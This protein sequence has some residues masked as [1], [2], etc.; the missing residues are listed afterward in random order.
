MDIKNYLLDPNLIQKTS[1]DNLEKALDGNLDITDPTNP[2]MFL[3][4]NSANVA[5]S[6]LQGYMALLRRV[7]PNLAKEPEDLFPHFNSSALANIYS[8]PSNAIFNLIINIENFIN[9]STQGKGY[10]LA[11]IPKYS[12]IKVNNEYTFT[13]LNNVVIKYYP[14]SKKIIC[15][16]EGNSEIE[17]SEKENEYLESSIFKDNNGKDWMILRIP[18]KQLTRFKISDNFIS[19]MAYKKTFK[20]EDYFNYI[21][22]K[23]LNP[24]TN[25]EIKLNITHD[26]YNINPNIP[27]MIVK[28]LQQEVTLELPVIYNLKGVVSDRFDIELFTTKGALEVPIT[29]YDTDRFVL[30][31]VNEEDLPDVFKISDINHFVTAYTDITGGKNEI[32]F[33]E[34]KNRI[35]D[36]TTGDNK[37]PLTLEEIKEKASRYGYRF[38][39]VLDTI[40]KREFLINKPIININPNIVIDTN[41]YQDFIRF[42]KPEVADTK[43]K[44]VNEDKSVIIEPYQMFEFKDGRLTILKE[45][46]MEYIRNLPKSNIDEY[47]N[48]KIFFNFF[49]YI[50]DNDEKLEYRIYD[51]S[52]PKIV[53]TATEYNNDDLNTIVVIKSRSVIRYDNKYIVKYVIDGN[54]NIL[55]LDVE[56]LYGE[57]S[58]TLDN[59]EEIKFNT[60]AYLDNTDLI[61]EFT[62]PYDPYITK[63]DLMQIFSN[64]GEINTA[65]IGNSNKA[66][67]RLYTKDPQAAPGHNFRVDDI[68]DTNVVAVIYEDE[69]TLDFLTRIDTLFS[70]YYIDYTERKF[71]TYDKDV[72]LTYSEDV[73]ELDDDGLPKLYPIYDE[74]GNIVDY[75]VKVLHKKGDVVKNENGDPIVK[76]KKGDIILDK[77]GNPIIDNEV[78]VI[79]NINIHLMEDIYLRTSNLDYVA[80]ILDYHKRLR[81]ILRKEILEFNKQLLE[82]TKFKYISDFNLGKVI[83]NY[84]YSYLIFDNFLKPTITLYVDKDSINFSLT[85]EQRLQIV[86]IIEKYLV[87]NFKINDLE[88]EIEEFLGNEVKSIKIDLLPNNDIRYI[89]YSEKSTKFIIGKRLKFNDNGDTYVD[90]DVNIVTIKI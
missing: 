57:L 51:V 84:N 49:K 2:F 54:T 5:A 63:N 22:V 32:D 39:Y 9:N 1:L 59:N 27:T 80:Y 67:F 64:Y 82:N 66:K 42:T 60:K 53:S 88:K 26:D 72:Y 70:N 31:I 8:S 68:S 25:K 40:F 75:E 52:E 45:K 37:I 79:H 34:L 23:T 46:E 55:E 47:N 62:I 7:Y 36:Y 61:F 58:V 18:M 21:V 89:D 65:Y 4:E 17:I 77:N 83:L 48:R 90:A 35:I 29:K 73:Y 20:I 50:L 6:T 11:I 12:Y 30:T 87:D 33:M 38:R 71:K 13:L 28:A 81:N 16:I 69:S 86:G 10:Y 41:D 24:L 85:D 74:N 43:I 44:F 78:G 15:K 3:L 56:E 76:H 14:N 19:T